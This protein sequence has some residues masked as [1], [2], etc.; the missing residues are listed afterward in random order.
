MYGSGG[1]GAGGDD[2]LEGA[3][4]VAEVGMECE[5]AAEE[6]KEAGTKDGCEKALALFILLLLPF[7]RLFDIAAAYLSRK[8]R[9]KAEK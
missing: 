9:E 6:G 7:C 4:A 5:E 1:G 3:R 8:S 2:E